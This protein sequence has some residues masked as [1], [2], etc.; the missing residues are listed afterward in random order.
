[1][2]DSTLYT[3]TYLNIYMLHGRRCTFKHNTCTRRRATMMMMMTMKKKKVVYIFAILAFICVYNFFSAY[4]YICMHTYDF[5]SE[6][7][8]CNNN[9]KKKKSLQTHL[10]TQ[11][12]TEY[13]KI[14]YKYNIQLWQ[15]QPKRKSN[16]REFKS[17]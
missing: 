14:S 13:I 3:R 4:F 15:Y 8:V 6:Y 7:E 17:N 10:F 9:N 11:L 16:Q 12:F 1:M 5:S 2:F